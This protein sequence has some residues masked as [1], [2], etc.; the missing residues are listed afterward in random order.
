[1]KIHIR[2]IIILSLIANDFYCQHDDTFGIISTL[3]LPNEYEE[4]IGTPINEIPF[5]VEILNNVG[6]NKLCFIRKG[7]LTDSII[8]SKF[9]VHLFPKQKT[10]NFIKCNFKPVFKQYLFKGEQYFVTYVVLP[11]TN[12][13][14]LNVGQYS[15]KGKGG[16]SWSFELT[17]S[18]SLSAAPI[19]LEEMKIIIDS[20]SF[21]KIKKKRSEALALGVLLTEDKDYVPVTIL[22]QDKKLV[23]EIRLKG[24]WVDHLKGERKWSYKI[25]LKGGKTIKGM[26]KF[27]IHHPKARGY[28]NENLLHRA[29]KKQGLIGLRYDYLN[30]SLNVSNNSKGIFHQL[31]IYAIEE[32]FDKRLIENNNRRE[33]LVLKFNEERLWKDRA[34]AYLI[35]AKDLTLR[36]PKLQGIG[37]IEAYSLKKILANKKLS[38]QFYLAKNMLE[39]YRQGKLSSIEIFDLKQIAMYTALANLFGATHGL[40][41]H[42]LRFY[43]NPITSL[44]EPISFDGGGGR[45]LK[46][47]QPYFRM[48]KDSEFKKEFVKALKNVSSENFLNELLIENKDLFDRDLYWLSQEFPS[49][50]L[51]NKET[52]VKNA[53]IIRK[54][55]FSSTPFNGHLLKMRNN[56]LNLKIKSLSNFDIEVVGLSY[57]KKIISL[58]EKEIL[59]KVG[60]VQKYELMLN[61][62]Y[63]SLFNDKVFVFE[64]HIKKFKIAYRINGLDKIRY[65]EFYPYPDFDPNYE[66]SSRIFKSSPLKDVN[67]LEIN[68]GAKEIVFKKGNWV[69]SED[70]II[71]KEYKVFAKGGVSID[72]RNASKIISYSP[73]FFL[74]QKGDSIVIQSSDST[75]QGVA[76]LNSEQKSVFKFVRFSNLSNPSSEKW[77][78]SGAVNFYES[79]IL[80]EN[81]MFENNRC[82]DALN[83]IRSDFKLKG[84]VFQN[85]YSDAFDGDFVN[86]KLSGIVFNDI[87]NDAID[88]SGSTI[89]VENVVISYSGDKGVSAGEGSKITGRNILI[90]ESEIGVASK[91]FSFINIEHLVIENCKLGFTAFQKK[92]EFSSSS[93]I[94]TKTKLHNVNTAYLIES[95]SELILNGKVA[96]I[97]EN[98]LSKMYG[99]L[100]GKSS[101]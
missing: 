12:I 85:I 94:A 57:K 96:T 29:M 7:G 45:P 99:E 59:L 72:L 64:K 78:L 97:S 30:V 95:G 40:I 75:G 34:Q 23:G 42:N 92:P 74:G 15:Y 100:Y 82:E 50:G 36:D 58:N 5:Q 21:F 98:V 24:D 76:V 25:K 31:G 83:I 89:D 87:G 44:L 80:M 77:N 56:K 6:E 3:P 73:M 27:A 41:S 28:L 51:F 47:I 13:H 84:L 32:G 62:N 91:D 16:K 54:Y 67:C 60:D 10:E 43:Y 9:Y 93:I 33:G 69:I 26:K 49:K 71:P 38:E 37:P 53:L 55:V 61:S 70:I 48:N 66:N 101:K 79:E 65:F 68:D 8:N 86:G 18:D 1:M 46:K 90:K 20:L 11:H 35:D 22:F 19:P 14:K 2:L 52:I 4:I 17:P 63:D 81:V 88:V 39:G